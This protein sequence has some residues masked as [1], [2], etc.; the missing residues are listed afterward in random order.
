MS[1]FKRD[2]LPT[3]EH[4]A[5]HRV[6]LLHS[7]TDAVC[8]YRMAQAAKEQLTSFCAEV[9]LVDYDDGHGWH[10]PVFDN[11]RIGMEWLQQVR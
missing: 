9:T 4:A 7:P 8:P 5:G 2:E 1:V 11:I 6:Y 3:L 10:G